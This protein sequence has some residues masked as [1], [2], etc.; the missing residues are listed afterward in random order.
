[1]N[2]LLPMVPMLWL[3]RRV[4]VLALVLAGA[5][6][7]DMAL[8]PGGIGVPRG[9]HPP[10]RR[11]RAVARVGQAGGLRPPPPRLVTPLRAERLIVQPAA[12]DDPLP[13]SRCS[14]QPPLGSWHRS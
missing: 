8:D 7:P 3:L 5:F 4:A 12:S 1:M 2:R 14:W 11:P 13:P 9:C 10:P 6:A